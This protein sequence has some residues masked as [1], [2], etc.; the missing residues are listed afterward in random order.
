MR[1][2]LFTIA[3]FSALFV[4]THQGPYIT[5]CHNDQECGTICGTTGPDTASP[6]EG[7][8]GVSCQCQN[9]QPPVHKC[10]K[11]GI[12]VKVCSDNKPP[13]CSSSYCNKQIC[14]KMNGK[15]A[16]ATIRSACPKYHP[17]NADQC[18]QYGGSYCTCIKQETIDVN[19]KPYAELG[20]Q[21]GFA[22]S[23]TIGAC[24]NGD[25]GIEANSE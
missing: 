2:I 11:D 14:I 22:S 15:Q 4:L 6:T 12:D 16:T 3:I 7:L 21:N 18:C 20:N 9:G 5:T 19:W 17:Q 13:R 23:V 25:T 10:T 8:F 1:Q 24:G